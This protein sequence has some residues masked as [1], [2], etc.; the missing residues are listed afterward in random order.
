MP[1]SVEDHPELPDLHLV[2]ISQGSRAIDERAIDVGAVEAAL[3]LDED[4][5]VPTDELHV[6]SGDGDVVEEDVGMGGSPS[7]RHVVIQEESGAQVG[8]ALDDEHGIA[9]GQ[10]GNG[11]HDVGGQFLIVRTDL[12]AD[13][14]DDASGV[15]THLGGHTEPMATPGAEVGVDAVV[16]LAHRTHIRHGLVMLAHGSPLEIVQW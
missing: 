11:I 1:A 13:H 16:V 14:R 4:L 9:L 5:A 12:V 10:G 7:R 3:V 15:T 8:A 6:M 2:A